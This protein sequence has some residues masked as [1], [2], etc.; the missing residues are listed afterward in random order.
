MSFTS[1]DVI[2]C[3]CFIHFI[4]S[5]F[6]FHNYFVATLFAIAFDNLLTHAP[7]RI[8]GYAAAYN[9]PSLYS[10]IDID[11]LSFYTIGYVTET[12]DAVV[13]SSDLLMAA[14][15]VSRPAAGTSPVDCRWIH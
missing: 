11:T 5:I 6:Q 13:G 9:L 15:S 8:S 3:S 4:T 14:L 10:D 2:K 1:D 7:L 12:R